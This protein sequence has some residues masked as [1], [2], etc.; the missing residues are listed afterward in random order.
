MI[1]CRLGDRRS[2]DSIGASMDCTIGEAGIAKFPGH[3]K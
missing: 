2:T 3:S 1:D